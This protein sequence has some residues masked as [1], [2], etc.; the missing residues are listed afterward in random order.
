MY[1][2]GAPSGDAEDPSSDG[3]AA[4]NEASDDAVDVEFEE[5]KDEDSQ[6]KSS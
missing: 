2:E 4:N 6:T 3:A 1:A 5:V